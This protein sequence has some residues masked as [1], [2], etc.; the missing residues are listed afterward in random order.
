MFQKIKNILAILKLW[1]GIKKAKEGNM[2]IGF[3]TTEFWTII[4]F[5]AL[6][7]FNKILGLGIS[8]E[9]LQSIALAIA[10]YIGGRSALKVAE[11]VKN[12]GK[13]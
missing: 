5:A 6:A 4:V 9:T 13:G 7:A 8:D 2:K 1:K 10:A 12:G 3:G 11:V